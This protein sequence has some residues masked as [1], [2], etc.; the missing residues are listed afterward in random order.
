M[1]SPRQLRENPE[2]ELRQ[3]SETKPGV[4]DKLAAERAKVLEKESAELQK[5]AK[6]L[7][8]EIEELAGEAPARIG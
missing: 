4:L 7:A 1:E 6:R 8:G 5:E 3:I 2:Y